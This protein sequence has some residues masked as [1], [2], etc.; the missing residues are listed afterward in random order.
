MLYFSNQLL[1]LCPQSLS[2]LPQLYQTRPLGLVPRALLA[3]PPALGQAL[4]E[5][6]LE[7]LNRGHLAGGHG[8]LPEEGIQGLGA[9]DPQRV[10]V[11]E[12]GQQVSGGG[13]GGPGTSQT[14]LERVQTEPGFGEGEGVP[15][16][17]V[18]VEWHVLYW[19]YCV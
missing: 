16:V 18:L 1:L 13:A 7:Q 6:P 10:L 11:L 3:V 2:L 8:H 4:P 17:T 19:N 9:R 15:L 12:E 14:V 5:P